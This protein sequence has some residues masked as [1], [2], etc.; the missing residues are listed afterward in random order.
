MRADLSSNLIHDDV[1]N[2]LHRGNGINCGNL[3]TTI[4][5]LLQNDVARQHCSYL[6]LGLKRSIGELW[7]ARAKDQV[8][9]KIDIELLLEV[10]FHIDFRNYSKIVPLECFFCGRHCV[11]KSHVYNL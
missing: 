1:G 6:V 2:C 5:L 8:W 10:V 9:T 4:L 3:D 7:I 11:V